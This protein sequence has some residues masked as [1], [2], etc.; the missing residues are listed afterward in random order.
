[1]AV[2]LGLNFGVN[3]LQCKWTIM[4]FAVKKWFY[5]VCTPG[6]IGQNSFL[7]EDIKNSFPI[8][9]NG[10]K[11]IN[12]A[13]RPTIVVLVESYGVNKSVS[14][15]DSLV[16]PFKKMN[17]SFVGL[18]QREAGHTQGAEW[19]D[20]LASNG[21]VTENVLPQQFRSKGLQTWFLHGYNA[22]FYERQS[23]YSK[24]GFDSLLF[25]D[26][27]LKRG[28][29]DCHYGFEGIC[30]SSIIN[31]IDSLLLDSVPKFIYW[32]TLDAHPPYEFAS[33]LEKS[34]VCNSLALSDVDCIYFTLQRNTSQR[35]AELASKH[36]NYRFVIRGDHRPMGSLEQSDFVQ[37]FYFRWV[38]LVILN[39]N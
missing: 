35:L 11:D 4:D 10:N 24:F 25:K 3:Q 26:D 34:S 37:S 12:D 6:I 8:W 14:Y 38:P 13:T 27:F 2:F 9:P 29:T 30:D 16:A 19:E 22:D 39:D 28:L 5:Q 15:T 21:T 17:A 1:M 18:Y 31:F 7:Q 20:F 36:P 33:V 23:N 32:T